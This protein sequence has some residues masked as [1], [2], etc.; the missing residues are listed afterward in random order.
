MRTT[1][2]KGKHSKGRASRSRTMP[3]VIY[4]GGYGHSG[5]TL[6]ESLLTASPD[7]IGCGEVV[8][9]LYNLHTQRENAHADEPRKIAPYGVRLSGAR[10]KNHGQTRIDGLM[11]V[12]MRHSEDAP[13]TNTR[14]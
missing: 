13:P 7:V 3:R 2:R 9:A 10:L 14:R 4:I 5:S 11:S 12:S 6:L 8:G 1:G